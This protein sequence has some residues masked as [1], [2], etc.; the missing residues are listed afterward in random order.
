MADYQTIKERLILFVKA[1]KIGQGKFETLCGLSNGYINNIRKSIQPD[2]LH[3]IALQYPELNTGWL[4]VGEGEMLRNEET[5]VI[6]VEEV[7]NGGFL[8]PLL[9]ISAQGGSLDDFTMSV[10]ENDCEM[11][12]SPI[13]GMD[14]AITIT[15][16]SMTPEY[17]SGSRVLIKRIN[18]RAFIDWGRV[19]VLDTCNGSIIKK[20][21]PG[22]DN[23]HIKCVSINPDY[24]PFEVSFSDIHAIFRVH[25]LLS[26]K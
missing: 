11:I 10:N 7:A 5:E 13:K 3:K 25:I 17:P 2:K 22:S 6:N 18:E 21:L 4:M 14:F 8:T 23:E 15:G 24:P 26:L 9:P 19:F 20:I 1:K 16:E 12:V